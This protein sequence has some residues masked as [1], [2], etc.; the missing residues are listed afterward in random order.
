MKKLIIYYSHTGNNSTLAKQVA[1]NL[2]ADS[3]ELLDIKERTTKKIVLDMIFH[4]RPVLQA[5]PEGPDRYDLILFMGPIWMFRI[6]SPLVSCMKSIRKDVR[7]YAFVS[8]SGGT[9]GPNT[10]VPGQLKKLLGKQLALSL[11][12][13]TKHFCSIAPESGVDETSTYSLRKHPDELE[14]LTHIVTTAV[15]GIQQSVH[16]G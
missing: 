12:L 3:F 7:Q 8:L 6:C 2:G 15:S 9:L 10:K 16:H 14:K 13:H 1:A 11:D 5:L 4:R